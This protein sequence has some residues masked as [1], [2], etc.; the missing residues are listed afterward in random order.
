M[1]AR[2][3]EIGLTL[4]CQQQLC[5]ETQH[6]YWLLDI[7]QAKFYVQMDGNT[8]GA[9]VGNA[10]NTTDDISSQAVEYQHFPDRFSVGVE[11]GCGLG[12]QT[13]DEGGISLAVN[14]LLRSLVQI[15][16]L[17]NRG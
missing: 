5:H 15:E 9:K 1:A 11:Y 8:P 4:S 3:E 6:F 13:V 10:Q 12:T 14:V 16:D 7:S 2:L 17:L